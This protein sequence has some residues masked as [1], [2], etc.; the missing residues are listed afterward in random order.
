MDKLIQKIK[1]NPAHVRFQDLE[2]LLIKCGYTMRQSGGGSSH[3]I[4]TKAGKK[5]LCIPKKKPFVREHYVKDALKK[6]EEEQNG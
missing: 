4:F 3:Y 6:I 2:K 1:Q 5:P